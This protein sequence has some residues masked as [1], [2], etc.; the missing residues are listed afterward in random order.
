MPAEESEIAAVEGR[1]EGMPAKEK[2]RE[3]GEW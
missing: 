2:G 1:E 3:D